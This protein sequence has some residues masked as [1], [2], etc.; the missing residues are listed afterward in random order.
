MGVETETSSGQGTAGLRL[1]AIVPVFNERYLVREMLRRLLAVSIPG[2]R[3]LEVIVVDDAST[4]GSGEIVDS[5]AAEHPGR[6]KVH[7]HETNQGKGAAVRTGIEAATGDLIVFQDALDDTGVS[8]PEIAGDRQF[9]QLFGNAV[10]VPR[11]L[12]IEVLTHLVTTLLRLTGGI[13][14]DS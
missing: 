14:C 11:P 2:I 9:H 1:S 3:E 10:E 4:D 13:G 8:Q 7:H 5:V 12:R 6:M